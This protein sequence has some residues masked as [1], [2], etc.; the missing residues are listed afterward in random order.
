MIIKAS[1]LP[2]YQTKWFSSSSWRMFTNKDM[3]E[4]PDRVRKCPRT[5]R[6][7]GIE[8]AG[9]GIVSTRRIFRG[10]L[11]LQEKPLLLI[12]SKIKENAYTWFD[13]LSEWRLS[14]H[15]KYILGK[16]RLPT[17][18]LKFAVW[19]RKTEKSFTLYLTVSRRKV[20]YIWSKFPINRHLQFWTSGHKKSASG[21]FR[22][23]NFALGALESSPDHGV[24]ILEK[25]WPGKSHCVPRRCSVCAADSTIPVL[26][27]VKFTGPVPRALRRWSLQGTST[28]AQSWPSVISDCRRE[29]LQQA[30][31]GVSY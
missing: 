3:L 31:G 12:E 25:T 24:N 14:Q 4:Q 23:N 28:L 26:Q 5:Y 1:S 19:R 22:T 11:I 27:T 30:T 18:E 17:S 7:T 10:E 8:Q 15:Q 20:T 29:W 16:K 6:V 13:P 2:L 9:L 21:I